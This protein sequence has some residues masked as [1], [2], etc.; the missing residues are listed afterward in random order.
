MKLP[1]RRQ[2]LHLAAGAAALPV[3]FALLFSGSGAWSQATR[4]IKIIVPLPPGGGSDILARV[5]AEQIGRA[6]GPT[7]V[8]E[9]RPGAGSAIGTEAASR[10]APDG[11]TL[12]INTASIVIGPHLRKLNYDPLTSFEP[13]CYLV[14]TPIFVVVNSASPYRTLADLLSEARAKPGDLTLASVGP[15]T[16][17][18]I[19]SEKLKLAANINLTYVPYSGTAPAITAL[20]GAHVTSMIAEH[21]AVAEQLNSGKLRALATG[22]RT[23]IE[24]F[25]DVPT[26]AESGY[27]DYEIDVWWGLFAPAKTPKETVSQLAGWF[28]AAL[29]APEMKP[30]FAVQGFRAVGVCGTDFGSFLRTQYNEY[31]RVI[32]ESNIKGE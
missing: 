13:I 14:N 24:S 6:Q 29:K 8:V 25:P 31:G 9:N 12:L 3:V 22:S 11:N 1:H 18:H 28:S 16:T 2:F 15:A 5:L 17:L 7:L 21:P 20:L 10:A 23:R 26:V 19:A 27:Q 32:R 4:T 30:K